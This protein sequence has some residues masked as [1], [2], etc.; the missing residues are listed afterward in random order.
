[1]SYMSVYFGEFDSYSAAALVA[2]GLPTALKNNRPLVRTW[3]KIKE[4]Q[5]P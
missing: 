3:I 2:K 1:M 5:A 4:D